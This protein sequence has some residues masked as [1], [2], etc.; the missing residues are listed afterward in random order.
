MTVRL[1]AAQARLP[2]GYAAA[3]GGFHP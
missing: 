1:H 3:R 2:A